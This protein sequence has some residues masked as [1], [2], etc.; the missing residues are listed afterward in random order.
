GLVSPAAPV[1]CA[2]PAW[3]RS[4]ASTSHISS[5]SQVIPSFGLAVLLLAGVTVIPLVRLEFSVGDLFFHEGP[6]SAWSREPAFGYFTKPPLLAWVIAVAERVC[7]TSEACVRAPS[8]VFYF[9][10]CLVVFAVA[11][12]LY[13][14]TVA[15][16]AAIATALTPGVI[17]STRI[18]STDVPLL[19][20]WALA[21][22][23]YVKLLYG[24]D[25]RRA[26]V[27]RGPLGPGS[28][29]KKPTRYFLS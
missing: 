17:F 24:A 22:L 10:T 29:A 19:F 15:F 27:L 13:D 9:A 25:R 16:F 21:L 18:I 7:G 14:D 5:R 11:R 8:P 23:A 4:M 26:P 28:L 3:K 2:G 20:F 1:Q 12:Q 6:N